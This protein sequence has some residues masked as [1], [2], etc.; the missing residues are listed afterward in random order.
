MKLEIGMN[1]NQDKY[2]VIVVGGGNAA[3][4]AALSA[5][6]NGA[7]VLV[8]EKAPEEERGGNSAFAGAYMRF[9]YDSAEDI[10]A[11]AGD[12]SEEEIAISDFGTYTEEQFFD[13]MTRLTQD[14][15]D[16]D[17]C[18]ILVKNSKETVRWMNRN[19][20]KFIPTYGRNA[21]KINGRFKFWGGVTM[22]VR[23]GGQGLIES[24]SK[25][26][27]KNGIDIKY[28]AWVRDLVHSDVGVTGVVVKIEGVTQT[29][30]AGAVVLACGSFEAN[31]EWRTR[32]LGR[33]WESAKVR[34][35][36]FNT[37]DGLEMALRIGAQAYG[38]WSGCHAAS[39]DRY[40]TEFGQH[41]V[42]PNFTRHGYPFAIVINADGKRFLDEGEDFRNYT[43]AKYGRLVLEQPGHFAWQV[44][45]SKV[46]NLLYDAYRTKYVTKVTANTIEELAEKMEGV[47]KTE[48]L[49]TVKEFNA[50]VK[51]DVPFDPNSKDGRCTV[52]LAI[53]KSNWSNPIDTPPYEACAVTCGITFAFGGIRI[54]NDAEVLNTLHQPIHG[55]FAAGEMV[56]GI[57]H[58]N[59]PGASGLTSGAVFGKIAGRSAAVYAVA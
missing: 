24:L 16:P 46:L 19:G 27:E 55:L 39:W 53:P 36:K 40:A 15:T 7:K 9:V 57:F 17:L 4:C 58:Y 38:N 54:T 49:K 45:D 8:L 28:N 47:N 42:S 13:D 48:F 5:R 56:G 43:Y 25:T 1:Q 11:L 44:F 29:I 21:F 59:Y 2:D 51:A 3:L 12:L 32:Y 34:G 26:A 6:E 33:G 18:E 50:A 30:N 14:R 35:S 31:P 37:A 41:G 52:G 10:I 20:V 23:G 22:V